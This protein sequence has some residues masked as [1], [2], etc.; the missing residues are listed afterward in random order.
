MIRRMRSEER[1]DDRVGEAAEEANVDAR[2]IVRAALNPAE[3]TLGVDDDGVQ[4][5]IGCAADRHCDAVDADGVWCDGVEVAGDG[6]EAGGWR[7]PL[8]QEEHGH[9]LRAHHVGH[10]PLAE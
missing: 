2:G 9:M 3:C 10:A 6:H 1:R 4:R 5:P 7:D 8:V